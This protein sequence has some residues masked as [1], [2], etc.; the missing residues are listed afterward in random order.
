M[1]ICQLHRHFGNA[2]IEL[3]NSMMVVYNTGIAYLIRTPEPKSYITKKICE[4]D[5]NNNSK[6]QTCLQ[7][8]K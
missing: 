7:N 1:S 6:Q 8:Y 4:T 3:K 5:R 2:T